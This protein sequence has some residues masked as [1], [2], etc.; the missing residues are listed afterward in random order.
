MTKEQKNDVVILRGVTIKRCK[1]EGGNYK[2]NGRVVNSEKMWRL[3]ITNISDDKLDQAISNH[4]DKNDRFTPKWARAEHVTECNL[5]TRFECPVQIDG[6]EFKMSYI[7][8][9]DD[10][11]A[12]IKVIVKDGAVY[13]IAIKVIENGS[14]EN[15]FDDM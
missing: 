10:C 15:P 3:Y 4:F 8:G 7:F 14:Y 5:K 2:V 12:D 9:G 1:F 13:P 6:N 11:K